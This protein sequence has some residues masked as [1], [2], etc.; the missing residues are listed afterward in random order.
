[1]HLW[2][3]DRGLYD[4]DVW[5]SFP[6]LLEDL[7][8]RNLLTFALI[9]SLPTMVP[10]L[11][12]GISFIRPQYVEQARTGRFTLPNVV[13]SAAL[14]N[15]NPFLSPKEVGE[16]NARGELHC[17]NLFGN[18]DVIDLADPA[19]ADFYRTSNEGHRFFHFGYAF[20]AMWMEVWPPHHVYELTELGMQAERQLP[21]GDG[22][23]ATLMR[24]TR[25]DALANP[26]TRFAGYF[27]P[28]KPRFH[29]SSGEQRLLECA[30]LEASDEDAALELHL[31]E[32]A[33][34]KRWRSIYA[35]VENADP[36]LLDPRDS[37][38][39]RRRTLLHYMRRHLEEL[40]L[41]LET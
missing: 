18:M 21:L 31:S 25:E 19:L 5:S 37:G 32:V 30:L 40:R 36:R 28:P 24:L 17:M 3:R 10:R 13:M 23:T 38:A 34:K 33:I 12:G 2:E 35:K 16:E 20:R 26:Y 27:F 7:V 15:R 8:D 41:Y 9:E 39:S 6:G 14:Q 1:M 11:L 22:R 29:F 4:P